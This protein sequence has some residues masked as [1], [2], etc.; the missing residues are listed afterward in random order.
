[1][2]K[3]MPVTAIALRE[4][5]E[6]EIATGFLHSLAG[7]IVTHTTQ[8][9]WTSN[10][11]TEPDGPTD[12]GVAQVIDAAAMLP[13]SWPDGETPRGSAGDPGLCFHTWYKSARGR[14]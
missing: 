7:I 14:W 3:R 13:E 6:L 1:M 2:S 10:G 9:D 8:R 4:N 5:V 12:T 11:T